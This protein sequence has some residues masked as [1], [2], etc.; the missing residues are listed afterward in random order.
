MGK[1]IYVDGGIVVTTPYFSPINAGAYFDTPPEG[2]E[3][4]EPNKKSEDGYEYLEIS[5]DN[6]QSIFNEYYARYEYADYGGAEY[7][8]R[9]YQGVYDDYK[10]RVNSLKSLLNVSCSSEEQ[11]NNLNRMVYFSVVTS[12]ETFLSDIIISKII[13]DKDVFDAF[14][15]FIRLTSEEKVILQDLRNS[16]KIAHWE[17]KLIELAM[18]VVYT[19]A[20]SIKSYFKKIFNVSIENTGGEL[21]RIFR[22]RH[23]LAHKNGRCKDGT[24]FSPKKEDI[25]SLISYLDVFA[26]QIMDKIEGWSVVSN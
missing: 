24:Y 3:V 17:Q 16:D 25:E 20:S 18:R 14:F 9:S 5:D 26:K 6:P 23:R 22:N 4:I 21:N 2:S 1:K 19:S 13:S 15:D 10:E 11:S 12:F 8:Y 7:L